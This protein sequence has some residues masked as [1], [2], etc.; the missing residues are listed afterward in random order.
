MPNFLAMIEDY[1][2]I[3]LSARAKQLRPATDLVTASQ[4]RSL[5]YVL[6]IFPGLYCQRITPAGSQPRTTVS[7]PVLIVSFTPRISQHSTHYSDSRDM[8]DEQTRARVPTA[9]RSNRPDNTEN[10]TTNNSRAPPATAAPPSRPNDL[11]SAMIVDGE[12]PPLGVMNRM[13]Y[14][15]ERYDRGDRDMID[16]GVEK[17]SHAHFQ[18]SRYHTDEGG[19]REGAREGR[20]PPP[21]RAAPQ[22]EGLIG[23]VKKFLQGA[24]EQV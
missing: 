1:R 6:D 2:C 19:S 8:T 13:D 23:K 11:E 9:P 21:P 4:Q 16:S 18:S 14:K 24:S 15:A 20:R 3:N 5:A 22:D 17:G 12:W 7:Q 10:R